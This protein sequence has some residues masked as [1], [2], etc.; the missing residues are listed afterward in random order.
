MAKWLKDT[1]N[2]TVPTDKYKHTFIYGYTAWLCDY[3][4]D[5]GRGNTADTPIRV[6]ES[7]LLDIQMNE[8]M[9]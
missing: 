2:Y 6:T 9:N 8:E 3:G 4:L 7:Y 5:H 1:Q